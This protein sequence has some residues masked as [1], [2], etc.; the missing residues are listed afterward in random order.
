MNV[1]VGLTGILA[2]TLPIN[3]DTRTAIFY[4]FSYASGMIAV[5]QFTVQKA[6][7]AYASKDHWCLPAVAAVSAVV[8]V[9]E[10][11]VS[12][13]GMEE[14]TGEERVDL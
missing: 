1:L 3:N 8:G 11:G 13:S 10:F 12:V 7:P 2:P 9:R 14:E 4:T 6:A 5:C